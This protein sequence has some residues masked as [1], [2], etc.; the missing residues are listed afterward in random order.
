MALLP[1]IKRA[2]IR[3]MLISAVSLAILATLV[4]NGLILFGAGR[5]VHLW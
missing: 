3:L 4:W 1:G 2:A 5:L